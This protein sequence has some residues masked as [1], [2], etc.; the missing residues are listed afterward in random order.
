MAK[1]KV[2]D[3]I[4]ANRSAETDGPDVP[5]GARYVVRGVEHP[6]YTG[7]LDTRVGPEGGPGTVWVN[8]SHF[9]LIEGDTPKPETTTRSVAV[10]G[11][12]EFRVGDVVTKEGG[13]GAPV[14]VDREA[15]GVKRDPGPGVFGTAVV[16]GVLYRGFTVDL[17]EGGTG[18]RYLNSASQSAFTSNFTGFEPG[19]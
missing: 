1:F 14:R 8:G 2:G 5:K 11:M 19:V 9:D 13:Y 10:H 7:V 15:P 16:N 3:R 4:I 12:S 17:G 18:F 6:D